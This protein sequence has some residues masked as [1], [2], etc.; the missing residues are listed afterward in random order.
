MNSHKYFIVPVQNVSSWFSQNEMQVGFHDA[1]V[2]SLD[3]CGEHLV[4]AHVFGCSADTQYCF[5][6]ISIIGSVNSNS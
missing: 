3:F 4:G 2:G 5:L 6:Q 1:R